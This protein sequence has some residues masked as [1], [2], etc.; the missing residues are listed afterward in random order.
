MNVFAV[1]DTKGEGRLVAVLDSEEKAIAIQ[2]VNPHYFRIHRGKLNKVNPEIVGW[3]L[4][5]N[6]RRGLERLVSP[7]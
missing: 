6:E 2:R 4:S 3:A 5:E 1:F 7:R